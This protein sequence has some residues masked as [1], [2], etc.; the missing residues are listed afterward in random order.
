MYVLYTQQLWMAAWGNMFSFI[1]W[2][3]IFFAVFMSLLMVINSK[4]I[5]QRIQT[6]F[7]E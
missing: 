4:N 7:G 2:L 6:L 5:Y 3:T 1:K